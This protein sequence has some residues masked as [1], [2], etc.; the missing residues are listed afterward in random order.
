MIE[1]QFNSGTLSYT[2]F[3]RLVHSRSSGDRRCRKSLPKHSQFDLVARLPT[4][5][6]M[7]PLKPSKTH[8]EPAVYPLSSVPLL[9]REYVSGSLSSD[10]FV[11]GL[12]RNGISIIPE[13]EQLIRRHEAD[14][15]V[16][17]KDF[18]RVLLWMG[19]CNM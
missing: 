8:E 16:T 3:I 17:F 10:G 5:E 13:L 4:R 7:D 19:A 1:S 14:N 6:T 2:T 12:S 15:S 9:V 18:G 11:S